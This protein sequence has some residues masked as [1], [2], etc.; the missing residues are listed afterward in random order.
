MGHAVSVNLFVQ[1]LLVLLAL[2]FDQG[3]DVLVLV[4][5]G[6]HVGRID[7]ENVRLDETFVNRLLQNGCK[8]GFKYIRV[9][10][11]TNVIFAECGEVGNGLGKVVANEPP[12]SHVGLDLPYGLTHG[13]NAEDTLNENDLNEDYRVDARPPG[14]LRVQILYKLIDEAEVDRAFQLPNQMVLWHELLQ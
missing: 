14:I 9:A 5:V 10:K 8:D 11:A 12:V 2:F 1:Q 13:T 7:E 6:F 4:G 3:F